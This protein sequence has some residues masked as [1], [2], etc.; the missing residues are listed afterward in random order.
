MGKQLVSFMSCVCESS[1]PFFIIYTAGLNNLL[2]LRPFG[3]EKIRRVVELNR[4]FKI[5]NE[6]N[7]SLAISYFIWLVDWC[8]A[9]ALAI[10]QL[11]R[12]VTLFR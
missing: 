5:K 10:F 11:Y 9:P 1:A 6:K 8:L 3:S 4:Q 7:K 12:G 2:E